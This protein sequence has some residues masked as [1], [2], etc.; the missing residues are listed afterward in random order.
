MLFD[1]QLQIFWSLSELAINIQIV[2]LP[3]VTFNIKSWIGR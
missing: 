1:I 2:R 3:P